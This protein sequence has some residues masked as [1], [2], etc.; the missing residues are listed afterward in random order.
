[1]REYEPKSIMAG[2]LSLAGGG[3]K[4]FLTPVAPS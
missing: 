3:E 1:M 4:Y 2:E